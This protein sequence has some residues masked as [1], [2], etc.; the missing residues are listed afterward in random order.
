MSGLI[1]HREH[2]NRT[3]RRLAGYIFSALLGAS[4][5][6]FCIAETS[7]QTQSSTI[8]STAESASENSGQPRSRDIPAKTRLGN[9]CLSPTFPGKWGEATR[10]QKAEG[11]ALLAE[12]GVDIAHILVEWGHIEKRSGDYDWADTDF[13][14]DSILDGGMQVSII[15]DAVDAKLPEDIDDADFADEQFRKRHREFMGLFLD[16]YQTRLSYLWLGNEVN[17]HLSANDN[18]QYDYIG[19]F[20]QMYRAAKEAHPEL[21]VGLIV[22]FP[23][24]DEPIVYDLVEG[25]EIADLI[26]YTY[27]P[28]WL[29]MKPEDAGPALDRIHAL[30]ERLGTRYAIVETAWSSREFGGSEEAQAIYVSSYLASLEDT[31]RDTR[32][33]TCYWGLFDPELSFWHK[34]AL[35]FDSGVVNWLETLGLVTNDNDPKPAWTEFVNEM[36]RLRR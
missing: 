24:E 19:F 22:T 9:T 5:P 16:R 36:D 30:N 10:E 13:Q 21:Q 3:I 32:E 33:F 17:L 6:A 11:F 26:G 23:Y 18:E 25:A 20:E 34:T 31:P 15:L 28:Q 29:S 35:M 8:T 27:Y 2:R 4:L 7:P 12:S 14:I 1:I